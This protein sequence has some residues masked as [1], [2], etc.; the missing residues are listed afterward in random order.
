MNFVTGGPY[1]YSSWV[2]KNINMAQLLR[3][4]MYSIQ[5]MIK[6]LSNSFHTKMAVSFKQHELRHSYISND[7]TAVV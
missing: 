6:S 3:V 1:Y 2:P 4:L 5:A 7:F